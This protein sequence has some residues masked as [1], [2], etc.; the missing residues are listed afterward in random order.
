MLFILAVGILIFLRH[1]FLN[2][3]RGIFP[4]DKE[5]GLFG[6]MISI[7]NQ[8]IGLLIV[9]FNIG[10]AFAPESVKLPLLYLAGGMIGAIY[11]YRSIRG[12]VIANRFLAF[13]KFHFFIY[14]C[15]VE[16]APIVALVKLVTTWGPIV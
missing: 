4:F 8:I 9:P 15:T 16:I 3:L 12:L 7:Y 10:L 11:I 13:H 2:V 5:L 6:Y 1:S 14:L